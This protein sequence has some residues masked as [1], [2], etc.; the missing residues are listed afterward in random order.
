MSFSIGSSS[1]GIGPRSALSQFGSANQDQKRINGKVLFR[2]LGY[3]RPY[4]LHMGLAFLLTL[5]E[6]GLTLLTPYLIK[7]A[8]DEY[9]TLND[10]DGLL[11][12]SLQ[13]GFSFLAVFIVSSI[14]RYLVSWVSQR[15]L[16]KLRQDRS[17]KSYHKSPPQPRL[18]PITS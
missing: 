16:A 14:Q 10:I 5:I 11:Q 2:L 1:S 18:I 6:S 13:I 12:I 15:L 3:L 17:S 9:I 8:L 7:I 4:K